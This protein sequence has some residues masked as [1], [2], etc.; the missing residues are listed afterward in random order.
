MSADTIYKA[1]LTGCALTGPSGCAATS[2]GDGP[3]DI[4]TKVQALLKSAYDATKDNSSVPMTPGDI[5]CEPLRYESS[6]ILSD[7][8]HFNLS[9]SGVVGRDVLSGRLV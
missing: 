6:M 3:L 7:S 4:D 2:E 8:S 9:C 1:L 5:R